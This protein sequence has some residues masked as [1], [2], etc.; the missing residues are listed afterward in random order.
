MVCRLLA[1]K[2][3]NIF[4]ILVMDAAGTSISGTRRRTEFFNHSSERTRKVRNTQ[5]QNEPL[6]PCQRTLR[7]QQRATKGTK[8]KRTKLNLFYNSLDKPVHHLGSPLKSSGCSFDIAD[9]IWRN[10]GDAECLQVVL[11]GRGVE[12]TKKCRS[13]TLENTQIDRELWKTLSIEA[14]WV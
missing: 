4:V 3:F 10:I 11:I 8:M 14:L 9:D 1:N 5:H 7:G 12:P 2:G 6:A 13:W